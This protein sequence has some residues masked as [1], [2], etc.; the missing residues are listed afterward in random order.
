MLFRTAHAQRA[1]DV[2]VSMTQELVQLRMEYANI[3]G[4]HQTLTDVLARRE[5][6]LKQA[7]EMLV[8]EQNQ[9]SLLKFNLQAAEAAKLRAEKREKTAQQ[10]VEMVNTLLVCARV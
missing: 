4:Q 7:E 6:E 2:P 5:E 10:E 9:A 1:T 8:A 3:T